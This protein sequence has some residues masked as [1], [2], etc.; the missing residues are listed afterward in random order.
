MKVLFLFFSCFAYFVIF[1]HL[2]YFNDTKQ[3][4]NPNVG[5]VLFFSNR[6]ATMTNN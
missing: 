4:S 6:A 1:S 5:W 2:F 3:I